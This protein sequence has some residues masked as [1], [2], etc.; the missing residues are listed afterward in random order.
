MK[1][2]YC[3]KKLNMIGLVYCTTPQPFYGAF[4]GTTWMSR[5]QKKNSGLYGAR[6]D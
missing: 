6:E 5:C 1:Y 2:L 4:S 3:A